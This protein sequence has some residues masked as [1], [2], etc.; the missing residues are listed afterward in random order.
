MKKLLISAALAFAAAT[1][2]QAFD[3]KQDVNPAEVKA[4]HP[5]KILGT[6]PGMT[7]EEIEAEADKH[8]IGLYLKEGVVGVRSGVKSAS[9]EGPL[10]FNTTL[11]DNFAM[12]RNLD[13]YDRMGGDMSSPASGS[14]STHIERSFRIP[15]ADAPSWDSVIQDLTDAYGAPSYEQEVGPGLFWILDANGEKV[16][17]NPKKMDDGCVV[18]SAGFR[19]TPAEDLERNFCSVQF[20]V[21]GT[22]NSSGLTARFHLQ[23]IALQ[24]ADTKSM[25]AQLEDEINAETKGSKL[26]L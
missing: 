9:F 2:A 7:Y 4:D 8:D 5:F 17:G 16:E 19:Y 10:S 26:D 12:Y 1:S 11:Y 20:H 23:D 24:I 25:S 6:V 13:E 21:T 15:L 18:P 22:F 14:V 3:V